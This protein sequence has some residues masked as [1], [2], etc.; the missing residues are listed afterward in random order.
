MADVTRDFVAKLALKDKELIL[1]DMEAG[2][3]SF[4]RGMERSV[5]TVL[6]V[7][8][9]SFESLALAEKVSYMAEGMGIQRVRAILNKV[10]SE[11]VRQKMLDELNKRNIKIIGTIFFDRALFEAGFEGKPPGDSKA[12]EDMKMFTRQLLDK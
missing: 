8:E 10:P 7:V 11:E 3:E 5:D 6:V 1:I 2:V 12:A 9:P 4:G